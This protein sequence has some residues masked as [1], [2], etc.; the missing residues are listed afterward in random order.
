MDTITATEN[1]TDLAALTIDWDSMSDADL[2]AIMAGDDLLASL[3][4][5]AH[6]SARHPEPPAPVT[7][8]VAGE[9][10]PG[11]WVNC[12][13]CHGQGNIG[14]YRHVAHGV[15]FRCGGAGKVRA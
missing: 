9:E 11:K 10:R 7:T 5:T 1:D 14:H 2:A 15:C 12:S 4:A 3:M 13:R 8:F 6:Y